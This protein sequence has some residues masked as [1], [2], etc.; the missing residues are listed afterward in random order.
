MPFLF[1]NKEQQLAFIKDKVNPALDRVLQRDWNAKL[2]FWCP[3]WAP[4]TFFSKDPLSTIEDFQ[5]RKVRTW[6]GINDIALSKAGMSPFV[7]ELPEIYTA[8]SRGMI[9]TAITSYMSATECKFWEVLKY[10]DLVP[11]YYDCN[12]AVVNLDAFN[13]LSPELQDAVM[14]AGQDTTYWWAY[15]ALFWPTELKQ[16]L[17][18]NGMEV[19]EPAPGTMEAFKEK[20]KPMYAE[21]VQ[22]ANMPE[23]TELMRQAGAID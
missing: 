8:L 21:W 7:V 1:E 19:V 10:I 14:L 3:G 12:W 15:D 13:E 2:L 23:V 18:D 11:L 5:G 17:I 6:G 4:V 16:M 9:D 22:K 20:V